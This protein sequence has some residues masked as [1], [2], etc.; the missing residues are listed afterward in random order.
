L[1]LLFAFGGQR[2]PHILEENR[3]EQRDGFGVAVIALHQLLGG[4]SS[5]CRG[6]AELVGQ[7]ALV[8]KQQPVFAATDRKVQAYAQVAQQI[9]A[10]FAMRHFFVRQKAI[11]R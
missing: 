10:L 1:G 4:A 11:F 2:R 5:R 3:V 7:C 9:L 6:K 8:I